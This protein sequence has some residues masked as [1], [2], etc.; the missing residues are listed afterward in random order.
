MDDSELQSKRLAGTS[1]GGVPAGTRPGPGVR[2]VG[3]MATF[4]T[5]HAPL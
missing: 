3:P 4:D 2:Y 5:F 1:R